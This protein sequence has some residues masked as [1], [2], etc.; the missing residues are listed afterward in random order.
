MALGASN[1]AR[2]LTPPG[3]QGEL[4]GGRTDELLVQ[5]RSSGCG[6]ASVF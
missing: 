3:Q 1:A 2:A 6:C 5:V 4:G